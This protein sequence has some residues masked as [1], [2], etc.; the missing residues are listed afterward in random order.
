[1]SQGQRTMHGS[2]SSQ[3]QP[4]WYGSTFLDRKVVLLSD[5]MQALNIPLGS[6]VHTRPLLLAL[7][8]VSS[9]LAP[10]GT[11]TSIFG[12]V[13][14]PLIYF[15]YALIALDLIMGGPQAA[16]SS[17]TGAVVGH[18][19]WWGVWETR[20]LE[21]IGKAPAFLRSLVG[22]SNGPATGGVGG[23]GS[24]VHVIPP[25]QQ[26]EETVTTGH[27]WGS[28]QRLGGS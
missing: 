20:A 28:G 23:P 22:N 2:S 11:Q 21:S 5:Y 15:P 19:W 17:V 10:P 26:R 8:Y 14:I 3:Q 6:F 24:G 12:L 25:R 1:M 18:L 27:R 7:T 13:S 4:S 16:A 9:R